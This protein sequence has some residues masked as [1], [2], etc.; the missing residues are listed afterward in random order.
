MTE[1][2]DWDK[3]LLSM[4]CLHIARFPSLLQVSRHMTYSMSIWYVEPSRGKLQETWE[5]D[6]RS[7]KS[8]I[9]H[10]QMM[11][12][13]LQDVLQE[14]WEDE[15]SSESVI[16]HVLMMMERLVITGQGQ[17]DYGTREPEGMVWQEC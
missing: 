12:E 11:R 9:S 1:G 15:K 7:S 10:A 17:P 13:R 14:T 6:E 2:K 16:S 4:C 8:V 5:P 3:L